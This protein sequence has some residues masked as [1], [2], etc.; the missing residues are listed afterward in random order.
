MF[1][2]HQGSES[3]VLVHVHLPEK[4]SHYRFSELITLVE[5]A[6]AKVAATISAKRSAPLPKFFIGRGKADEVRQQIIATQADLVV[7]NHELTPLQER[8]L[9]KVLQCRVIDRT[10]IILDIFA[11]RAR[12]HEGKL[13][14]ELAQLRHLSTRLVRGWTH[15]ERQ[16]G[17]IGLRGPGETQLESDRRMLA[18]RVKSIKKRLQKVRAQRELM[19]S[20]RQKSLHPT[21]SLVGYTNAGKSTL[22]N[23][24][25]AAKV[26]AVDQVFATLDPTLRRLKTSYADPIIMVDTVGFIEHLPHQL[27]EAF[28]ATLEE[29]RLADLLIHV[30]DFSDLHYRANIEA[31]NAVLSEIAA[32]TVPQLLVYNKIDQVEVAVSARFE[33]SQ[34]NNLGKI[35]LSATSGEGVALL[36]TIITDYFTNSNNR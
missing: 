12:T 18:Q 30:V 1:E 34:N 32:D 15:L 33:P 14:V 21:V 3:A 29:T 19:R 27:I 26:A 20:A 22:F 23:Q 16:K 8:N 6:G 28:H 24:L 4:F 13:Q 5:S 7:F 10:R 9:E 11:K 31:V 36:M 2:C 25:T 35:W 17:G